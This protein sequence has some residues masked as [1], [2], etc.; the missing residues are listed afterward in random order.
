MIKPRGNEVNYTCISDGGVS[1]PCTPF[2]IADNAVVV[3][4]PVP[5]VVAAAVEVLIQDQ[6]L[7]L[8]L[9]SAGKELVEQ[10]F[11]TTRQM[12][13]YAEVYRTLVSNDM[14]SF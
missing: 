11:N 2:H 6:S 9:G 1:E 4:I 8:R 10:Y 3:N 12:A 7:R 13:Q 14:K 5:A